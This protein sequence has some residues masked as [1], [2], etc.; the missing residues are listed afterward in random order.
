MKK[1]AII[2]LFLIS[3]ACGKSV[4]EKPD[5]LIDE[6]KMADIMYDL[7]V[8]E[9][10]QSQKQVYLITNNIDPDKYIY[11]KYKIDS[12]QFAKSNQYYASDLAKYQKLYEK[13]HKRLEE[14]RKVSDSLA[15]KNGEVTPKDEADAPR[16]E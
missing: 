14:S 4:V 10:L 8:L 15:K 7:A 16:V 13:V 1:I 12:L 6:D 5:N 3:A 11:K 2:F 9:A